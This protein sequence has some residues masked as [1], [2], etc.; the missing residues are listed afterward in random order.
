MRLES[1]CPIPGIA[2]R[3]T[4]GLPSMLS[5]NMSADSRSMFTESMADTTSK[6]GAVSMGTR[7]GARARSAAT[8]ACGAQ[9]HNHG[10]SND[11]EADLRQQTNRGHN[12]TLI[13]QPHKSHE[14][15]L[16]DAQELEPAR[17]AVKH[18]KDAPGVNTLHKSRHPRSHS[19]TRSVHARRPSRWRPR[20]QGPPTCTAHHSRSP[21]PQT[22][23]RRQ[24][25]RPR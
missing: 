21:V 11:V 14:E 19:P 12:I 23:R 18:C 25:K 9:Q 6:S 5:K 24:R 4:T 13:A 8:A 10:D 15:T 16:N 17:R 1:N 7:G 20:Q 2:E 3:C 22:G